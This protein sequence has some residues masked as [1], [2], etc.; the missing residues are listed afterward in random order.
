VANFVNAFFSKFDEFHKPP[1]HPKWKEASIAAVIPGWTRFKPAQ[2]W[3]D[4]WRA[5]QANAAKGDSLASFKEFMARI[6][7][8]LAQVI[9]SGF[10]GRGVSVPIL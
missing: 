5:Q 4:N 8:S 3:I 10:P 9:A 6:A 1:R 2:D 7:G